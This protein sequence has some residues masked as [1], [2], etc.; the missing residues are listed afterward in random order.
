MKTI[1]MNIDVHQLAT[2][3]AERQLS[4]DVLFLNEDDYY[5]GQD[6]GSV[7][8]TEKGQQ[9]FNKYYND[10]LETIEDYKV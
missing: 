8:L 6:D 2:K 9:Y 10:Y 5:Q 7:A 4:R 1:K 3:L